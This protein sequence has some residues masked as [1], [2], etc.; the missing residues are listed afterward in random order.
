MMKKSSV[1][2]VVRHN[3]YGQ[4]ERTVT[5]ML[6][7]VQAGRTRLAIQMRVWSTRQCIAAAEM[8]VSR[9]HFVHRPFHGSVYGQASI[10]DL[11]PA[12]HSSA[13]RGAVPYQLS[14][15]PLKGSTGDP[16]RP[17]LS[18]HNRCVGEMPLQL[19]ILST[20]TLLDIDEGSREILLSAEI[21]NNR[22]YWH[23]LNL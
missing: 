21:S 13:M 16:D 9:R 8:V 15:G 2:L 12:I 3:V 17:N 11:P 20:A 4:F 14:S 1:L 23:W 22:T 6:E 7:E 10:A 19:A 5:R 18:K